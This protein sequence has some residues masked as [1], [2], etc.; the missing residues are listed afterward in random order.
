MISALA[1]NPRANLSLTRNPDVLDLYT[2]R[3]GRIRTMR[4]LRRSGLFV[5]WRFRREG[6]RQSLL[7]VCFHSFSTGCVILARIGNVR[8]HPSAPPI[9]YIRILSLKSLFQVKLIL[10][11]LKAITSMAT[12]GRGVIIQQER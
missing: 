6:G 5:Q 3:L 7:Q 11:K 4:K 8:I 1:P 12:S 2:D 9:L 10:K